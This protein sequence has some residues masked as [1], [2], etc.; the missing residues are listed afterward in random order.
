MRG[1]YNLVNWKTVILSKDR[2]GLGI[3]NLRLQNESLLKKWLWR[4]TEEG[5]ALCK[6]VIKAMYGELS[7]W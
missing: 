2:G 3:R 4:Y 7:P 6:E 1:S 5:S